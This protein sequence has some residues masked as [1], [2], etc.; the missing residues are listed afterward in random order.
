M[1]K[2]QHNQNT[3]THLCSTPP[4]P[5]TFIKRIRTSY[6]G[7]YKGFLVDFFPAHKILHGSDEKDHSI[8]EARHCLPDSQRSWMDNLCC[9]RSLALLQKRKKVKLSHSM[10][11]SI[12]TRKIWHCISNQKQSKNFLITE[13]WVQIFL[14]NFRA[15]DSFLSCNILL[16]R[17]KEDSQ[18]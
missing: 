1:E 5:V 15:S 13:W 12:K 18:I 3:P 9:H 10:F 4:E 2:K 7:W 14:V 16:Q 11:I 17:F 8:L 6:Y